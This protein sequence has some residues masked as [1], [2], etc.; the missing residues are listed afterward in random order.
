MSDLVYIQ[1]EPNKI[2]LGHGALTLSDQPDSLKP[3]FYFNDYFLTY[4]K[5]W[6]IAEHISEFTISEFLS[7]LQNSSNTDLKQETKFDWINFEQDKF[8]KFFHKIKL[9]ISEGIIEKI[10][11]VVFEKSNIPQYLNGN[12]INYISSKFSNFCKDHLVLHGL[13]INRQG[14]CGLTPEILVETKNNKII[15]FALAGTTL[16]ANG[17]KSLDNPKDLREHQLV[18]D[19]IHNALLKFGKPKVGKSFVCR[20][21]SLSHL[22]A[23]VSV[24]TESKTNLDQ[25]VKVLHPTAA[26]GVFPR[27]TNSNVILK[28]S[29]SKLPRGEFA[30]PFGIQFPDGR[31][32]CIASIRSCFWDNS[33]LKIAAGCGII[34]ESILEDEIEELKIKL[35]SIKNR[36]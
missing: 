32:L 28:S 22:K 9:S 10:V 5:P 12:F 25:I 23:E 36:F 6:I 1:T 24:E 34:E 29:D 20:I 17:D 15:S 13:E 11:P 19:D 31:S 4:T 16:A 27:S 18:V 35:N 26:L 8:K 2:V 21:G 33:H 3:C 7:F 30:S 14:R